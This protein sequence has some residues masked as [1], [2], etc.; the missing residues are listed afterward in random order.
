MEIEL[1][2]W[3]ICCLSPVNQ[4]LISSHMWGTSTVVEHL[5]H[6]WEVDGSMPRVGTLTAVKN[7]LICII[8]K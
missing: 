3:P 1:A 8:S 6:E 7:I 4:I 5:S 2:D